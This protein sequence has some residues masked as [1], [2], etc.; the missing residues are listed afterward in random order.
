MHFLPIAY[1]L[2]MIIL[3]IHGDVTVLASVCHSVKPIIAVAK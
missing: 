3:F 2:Y 1:I